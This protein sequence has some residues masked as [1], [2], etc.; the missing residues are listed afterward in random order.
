MQFGSL[1][2]ILQNTAG[3]DLTPAV[4][5]GATLLGWTDRAPATVIAWDGKILTV[6]SCL[7][8]PA[9]GYDYM[10]HQVYTYSEDEAGYMTSFRRDP[11]QGGKWREVVQNEKGRWVWVGGRKGGKGLLLGSRE[12]FHDPCF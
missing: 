11:A 1:Q 9:P 3:S 8:E 6:R 10:A 5:M 2:N 7:S 12:K 4:G